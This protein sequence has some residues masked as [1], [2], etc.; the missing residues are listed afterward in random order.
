MMVDE[1]EIP[2]LLDVAIEA[3][4]PDPMIG[5]RLKGAYEIVSQIGEGGMGSVYAAIQYPLERK[6]AVK[7]IRP[8][9]D[10]AKNEHYFMR[11]VQ[12]INMLR[13]PNVI[14]ILD[15]GKEEDGT[16]YL[17][18]EHLPGRTLT[19]VIREDFPLD[20]VRIC[21]ILIQLLSALE[22]AHEK[23][24]VHCDLKPDNVMLEEVA[25]QADF[26]KV[27]DFGIAKFKGPAIE[28]GPHTQMGKI[29]GTFDYMSPEQIMGVEV[30]G[31]ADVWSVGILLYEMLTKKRIFH[32]EDGMHILGRVMQMPIPPPSESAEGHEVPSVLDKITLRALERNIDKRLSSAEEMRALL[33]RAIEEL[34]G[35]QSVV[36]NEEAKS[37]ARASTPELVAGSLFEQKYRIVEVLAE[38]DFATVVHARHEAMERDVTL[39]FL[40]PEKIGAHESVLERF[41]KEIRL[42]SRLTSARTTTVFDFGETAEGTPYMVVEHVDGTSLH[43][44]IAQHGAIKPRHAIRFCEQI[45]DSL[46]EA[47][48]LGL[49]HRDLRPTNIQIGIVAGKENQIK[50]SDYAVAGLLEG[51]AR[52]GV[53]LSP[54]QILGAPLT[55]ASDL[56]S[57]G[58]ILYEMLSGKSLLDKE[59]GYTI[60]AA[61]LDD[62]PEPLVKII[63]KATAQKVSDRIGSAADFRLALERCVQIAQRKKRETSRSGRHTPAP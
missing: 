37:V 58:Q 39:K 51:R 60:S 45:L 63:R 6:V 55:P 31:R 47:H 32:H 52:T 23:G 49:L 26:V 54:E 36:F 19:K 7:V 17:V 43:T 27:L 44:T 5:K 10:I 38:G 50:V 4:E 41:Q 25:G 48:G 57:L 16:L 24:I 9:E 46:E 11:E 42:A 34:E 53:Y 18:M 29:V 12:A 30:D 28:A 3:L 22:Q 61:D 20:H 40:S 62:L 2:E 21:R 59:A 14:N 8:D 33:Q 1:S 56:Y 35:G 13:H 15:Y